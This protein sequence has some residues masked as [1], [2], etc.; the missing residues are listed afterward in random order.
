MVIKNGSEMVATQDPQ[1]A[2]VVL[3]AG[4]YDFFRWYP[5]PLRGIDANIE[6]EAGTSG[7]AFRARSAIYHVERIRAPILLLHGAQ[8]ERVSVRQAE[9]FAEKLQANGLAVKVKIFPKAT[10]RIP[11]DDQ[12]REIFPFLE[13]SRR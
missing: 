8:D 5:T 6:H 1:L 7:E 2:G 9:A 4:A 13:A 11:I 3:G 10:H 12:Y